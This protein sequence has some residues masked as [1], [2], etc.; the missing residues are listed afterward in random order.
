MVPSNAST[1]AKASPHINLLIKFGM[2]SQF[3]ERDDEGSDGG[4]PMVAAAPLYSHKPRSVSARSHELEEADS[5]TPKSPKLVKSEFVK[6]EPMSAADS[7]GARASDVSAAATFV[8]VRVEDYLRLK[9]NLIDA[10]IESALNYGGD[11]KKTKAQIKCFI[12]SARIC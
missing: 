8:Y 4:P 10:Q 9:F 6:T 11:G 3:V 1:C 5:Y 7:A 2:H 12:R